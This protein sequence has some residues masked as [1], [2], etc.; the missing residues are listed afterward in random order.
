V[1]D[2]MQ[3]GAAFIRYHHDPHTGA[4][5]RE[6][7]KVFFAQDETP[8]GVSAGEERGRAEE[9]SLYHCCSVNAYLLLDWH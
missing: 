6:I 3:E 8:L 5:R 4:T 7:I 9:S 2:L 1:I